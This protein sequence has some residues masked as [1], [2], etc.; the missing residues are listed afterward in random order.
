M[1]GRTGR[2]SRPLSP[3]L[4]PTGQEK[5]EQDGSQR[6]LFDFPRLMERVRKA[7]SEDAWE[8]SDLPTGEEFAIVRT[9]LTRAF[10]KAGPLPKSPKKHADLSLR[11]LDEIEAILAGRAEPWP[12]RQ[13]GLDPAVYHLVTLNIRYAKEQGR[14]DTLKK[15]LKDLVNFVSPGK[16]GRPASIPFDEVQHALALKQQG[17]SYAKIAR[18]LNHTPEA[19]RSALRHHYPQKKSD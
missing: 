3:P 6:R 13:L 14:G 10:A 11:R 15:D 12:R 5:V 7:V 16:R 9:L 17:L 18:Q 1:G 2:K 8:Q 4:K 19:V